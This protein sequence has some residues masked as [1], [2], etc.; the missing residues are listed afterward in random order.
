M[1][2]TPL[3][4]TPT[5]AAAPA[6]PPSVAP[7]PAPP[8]QGAP[9]PAAAQPPAAPAPTPIGPPAATPPSGAAAPRVSAADG[10]PSETSAPS[11]GTSGLAPNEF[12][13]DQY[14]RQQ[15]IADGEKLFGAPGWLVGV[16]LAAAP[17]TLRRQE[18]SQLVDAYLKK[19]GPQG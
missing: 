2:D 8:S 10:V 14:S 15:L 4:V 19:P 3:A 9:P 6:S 13:D 11:G 5:A 12:A 18:A 1:A 7:T 16:A 17:D